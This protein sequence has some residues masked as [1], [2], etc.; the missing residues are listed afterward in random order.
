MPLPQTLFERAIEFLLPHEGGYSNHPSDPG[1]ATNFGISLRFLRTQHPEI[2]DIDRDGDIDADDV[3][4]LPI[5]VAIELYRREFWVPYN[6]ARLPDLVAIKLFDLAVN[7]GPKP[8]H[9]CLQRALRACGRQD[10]EEDGILGPRTIAEACSAPSQLA[11]QA[12]L[13]SEAAGHYRALVL[14]NPTLRAFEG[15]WMRRAYA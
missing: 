14:R 13:R 6:Y 2:A 1:G 8:A 3:K 9:R 12:A 4:H 11:I 5:D 10:I 7:M 15:G